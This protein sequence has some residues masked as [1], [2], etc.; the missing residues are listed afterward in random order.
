MATY[1]DQ[2]KEKVV[3]AKEEELTRFKQLLEEECVPDFKDSLP[4]PSAVV[5][6]EYLRLQGINTKNLVLW[7]EEQ[8]FNV[9][10]TS[11]TD[12]QLIISYQ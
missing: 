12:A 11:G 7:L 5:Y 9:I 3:E 10:E 2:I 4:S 8:G 6:I 1:L